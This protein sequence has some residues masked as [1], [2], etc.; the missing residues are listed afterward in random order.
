MI[1]IREFTHIKG[2]FHS[3]SVN[4]IH[5]TFLIEYNSSETTLHFDFQADDKSIQSSESY[6]ILDYKNILKYEYRTSEPFTFI[7]HTITE[8]SDV[9]TGKI[10]AQKVQ[11]STSS[12]K[13]DTRVTHAKFN[14][15]FR[16][17]TN[18]YAKMRWNVLRLKC[19]AANPNGVSNKWFFVKYDGTFYLFTEDKTLIVYKIALNSNGDNAVIE[20]QNFATAESTNFGILNSWS[21]TE[22]K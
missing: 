15:E 11:I 22:P 3:S 12:N 13:F 2:V 6:F 8:P 10:T 18:D 17:S 16:T 21:F 4:N 7:G 14:F 20:G 19:W 9:D 1:G 5:G